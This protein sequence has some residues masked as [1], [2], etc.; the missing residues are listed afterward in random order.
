MAVV[1]AF[2]LDDLFAASGPARQ[3]D[4][5][6][7]GFGTRT[8]QAN[9]V[10]AG[11]EL[12]DFFGQ[13]HLALGGCAE[14]EAFQQRFLH[15]FHHSR[16][17]VAQDH[18]APGADVVDVLLAVGIPKIGALCP[19]HK[20]WR[21]THRFEGPYG[22]VHTTRNQGFGAVKQLLVA[23]DCVHDSIAVKSMNESGIACFYIYFGRAGGS[24]MTKMH[25]PAAPA[26]QWRVLSSG[27][28]MVAESSSLASGSSMSSSSWAQNIRSGTAWPMPGWK[29]PSR[30]W[31]R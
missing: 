12:D 26:P 28:S 31:S 16:V 6:H 24:R 21:A 15:R 2:E 1:A 5:A 11:H 18:G 4:G 8:D 13:L 20:A 14:T 19:L 23:V 27:K 9:H 7:T 29:P 22:R 10:Q 17:A 30:H 25:C 3:A